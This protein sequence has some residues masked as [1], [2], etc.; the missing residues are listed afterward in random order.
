MAGWA[1]VQYR[2]VHCTVLYCIVLDCTEVNHTAG[3]CSAWLSEFGLHL[4]FMA[5][6]CCAVIIVQCIEV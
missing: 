6:Q 2:K 5:V 3:L 4:P 1:G